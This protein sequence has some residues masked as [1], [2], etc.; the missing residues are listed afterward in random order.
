M[1]E[2]PG[3]DEEKKQQVKKLTSEMVHY[4]YCSN[5]I[6]KVIDFLEPPFLWIGTGEQEYSSELTHTVEV[7][8]EFTGHIPPVKFLMKN[9]TLFVLPNM[10]ISVPGKC[11]YPPIP[12][13]E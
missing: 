5:K 10:Y 7:F 11:G 3:I 6:Q 4:H 8:S 1:A 12:Q 2:N 13:Q 9:M